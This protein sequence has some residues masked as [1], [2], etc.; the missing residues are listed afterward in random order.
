MLDSSTT[1]ET[2][3]TFFVEGATYIG[4]VVA[5]GTD[6]LTKTAFMGQLSDL[7]AHEGALAVVPDL[8]PKLNDVIAAYDN[9]DIAGA[10]E[11]GQEVMREWY[12]HFGPRVP[13]PIRYPSEGSPAG[14]PRRE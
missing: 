1:A 9:G 10:E 12:A 3:S 8:I 14:R 5:P 13:L 11:L 7:L 2:A 6:Y 4:A